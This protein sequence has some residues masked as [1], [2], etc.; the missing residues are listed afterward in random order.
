[1]RPLPPPRRPAWPAAVALLGGAAGCQPAF[2]VERHLLGPPRLAALGAADGE[3]RAAVYSGLG[4]FHDDAP[5][6]WWSADGRPLGEG[7]GVAVPDGAARL[8]VEVELP[9][10]SAW[11]GGVDVREAPPL[12]ALQRA[13][14]PLSRDLSLAARRSVDGAPVPDG[15]DDDQ[16]ALRLSFGAADGLELRWMLVDA[17]ATVLELDE[18]RADVIAAEVLRDDGAWTRGRWTGPAPHAGLLLGLDGRGGNRWTWMDLPF[19]EDGPWLRIGERRLPVPEALPPGWVELRLADGPPPAG[20][21]V[22]QARWLA[23]AEDPPPPGYALACGGGPD[24]FDLAWLAEGRCVRAEVVGRALLVLSD[25]P[26]E[27]P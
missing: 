11:S 5:A 24:A 1:M 19:G 23:P 20:V 17:G 27:A 15:V 9:D 6:L 26:A 7:F 22:E 13:Q 4:L 10:G 25:P 14:V 2:P 16:D 21:E 8:E 18:A 12:G 3:A